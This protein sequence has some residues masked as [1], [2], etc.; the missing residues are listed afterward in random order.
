MAQAQ[1]THATAT[2]DG[3]QRGKRPC[4]GNPVPPEGAQGLLGIPSKDDL[5][6]FGLE[7][8]AQS[9]GDPNGRNFT[10]GGLDLRREEVFR[11][12][13]GKAAEAKQVRKRSNDMKV[14]E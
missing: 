13:G 10:L 11:P 5:A 3:A 12:V 6:A 14:W 4:L 8:C 2:E 7:D 1:Q 9:V